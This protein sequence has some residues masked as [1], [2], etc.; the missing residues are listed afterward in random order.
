MDNVNVFNIF[1]ISLRNTYKIDKKG[2]QRNEV[3]ALFIFLIVRYSN[4]KR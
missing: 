4:Y 3:R 1:N 2:R